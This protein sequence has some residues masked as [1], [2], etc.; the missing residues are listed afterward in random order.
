M[1]IV[2]ATELAMINELFGGAAFAADATLFAGLFTTMPLD[3]GT[4]GV[5]ANY[6]GY[7][8][9]SVTN[10]VTNFPSANP[11]L[12][13]TVITFPQSTAAQV[14]L[15][16]GM[17][18]WTAA[19]AG[20]LRT[21][22]WANDQLRPMAVGVAATDTVFCDAAHGWA[23]DTKVIVWAPAGVTLPTGLVAG[24]EYFVRAPSG[25]SL[26]LAAT[27]GGVAIDITADGAM[28]IARSRFT[29]VNIGDTPSFAAGAFS[30]LMD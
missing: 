21:Y 18:W 20:T 30:L 27:A 22:A 2:D 14:G 19:A 3:D 12:N 15:I 1:S 26:Q 24:T 6:A 17:G 13:G 4:G 5:E 9:V 29:N 11:K 23:L 25:A 10:N 28:I 16:K 7:A 8:R